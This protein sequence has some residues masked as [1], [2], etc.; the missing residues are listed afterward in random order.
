MEELCISAIYL[1]YMI[2][3]NPKFK[4]LS[5]RLSIEVKITLLERIII[6]IVKSLLTKDKIKPI[7]WMYILSHLDRTGYI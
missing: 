7:F 4:H 5:S 1:R 6:L 2:K 3:F